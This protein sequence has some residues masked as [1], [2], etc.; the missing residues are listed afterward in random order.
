MEI[1]KIVTSLSRTNFPPLFPPNNLFPP[2]F[3]IIAEKDNIQPPLVQN[4]KYFLIEI[5]SAVPRQALIRNCHFYYFL[6]E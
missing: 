5:A 3:S 2:S 1:T 6:M 4:A